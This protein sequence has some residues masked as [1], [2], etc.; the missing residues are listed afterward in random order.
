MHIS[1]AEKDAIQNRLL[2]HL[3]AILSM[4][5]FSRPLD[6]SVLYDLVH[7]NLVYIR[8]C[9]IGNSRY[10]SLVVYLLQPISCKPQP[11]VVR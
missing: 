2:K 11:L 10:G 5:S 7:P 3:F 1:L 9:L 8:K 6:I 4:V